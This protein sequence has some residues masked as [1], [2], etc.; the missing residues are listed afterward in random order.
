MP[1]RPQSFISLPPQ[2]L[3]GP[4]LL[5]WDVIPPQCEVFQPPLLLIWLFR[6]LPPLIFF[7]RPPQLLI[8]PFQP[9]PRLRFV[10]FQLLLPRQ[11]SF[12]PQVLPLQPPFL[13][14]L[15]PDEVA[16]LRPLPLLINAHV[17]LPLPSIV[18]L[19]QR[20]LQLLRHQLTQQPFELLPLQ[21]FV[22]F[23]VLP[24][25]QQVV[26]LLLQQRYATFQFQLLTLPWAWLI[27]L[28]QLVISPFQALL[29]SFLRPLR[30]IWQLEPTFP[31]QSFGEPQ[32]Y[33]PVL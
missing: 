16:Q 21:L 8:W 14:I 28:L 26:L 3:N 4:L 24:P 11:L 13:S 30:L 31:L 15:P 10:V 1:A 23:Q 29:I 18:M 33:F 19:L 25:P 6:P 32:H 9:P 20:Q 5:L 7:S 22:I 17:L 12:Q 27:H 2:L